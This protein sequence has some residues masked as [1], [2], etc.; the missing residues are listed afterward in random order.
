MGL[1]KEWPLVQIKSQWSRVKNLCGAH[2][3]ER[4]KWIPKIGEQDRNFG[5]LLIQIL[6][7]EIH[8]SF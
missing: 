4:L 8:I 6:P 7:K 5:G 1:G 3:A 2:P